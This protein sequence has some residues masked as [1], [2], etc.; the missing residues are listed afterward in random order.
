MTTPK[1]APCPFCGGEAS[2]ERFGFIVFCKVCPASIETIEAPARA[3]WNRRA[4]SPEVQSLRSEL[5][6]MTK[7]RD[8][9]RDGAKAETDAG[10]EARSELEACREAMKE[11]I[12]LSLRR[13]DDAEFFAIEPFIEEIRA[14]LNLAREAK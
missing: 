4:P 1:L 13:W 7:E 5:E 2:M 3:A 6:A 10:D 8:D 14:A 9:Y 11:R 12:E